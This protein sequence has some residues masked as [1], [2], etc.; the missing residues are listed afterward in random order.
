MLDKIGVFLMVVMPLL[1]SWLCICIIKKLAANKAIKKKFY[2]GY[3]ALAILL[4]I[5]I[6]WT[7]EQ[8]VATDFIIFG[9]KGYFKHSF[10]NF[11]D[12]LG[13][14]LISPSL[15]ADQFIPCRLSENL[16]ARISMQIVLILVQLIGGW[17]GFE[18]IKYVMTVKATWQRHYISKL[19]FAFIF[20]SWI[21]YW[22]AQFPPF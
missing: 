6:V 3:L 17:L 21:I 19:T 10:L 2:Y 15:I 14:L 18:S 11:F 4:V 7:I 20:L 9:I 5:S 22:V 1:W 16:I 8:V 12:I 13:I